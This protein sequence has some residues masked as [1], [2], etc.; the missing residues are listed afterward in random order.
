MLIKLFYMTPLISKK[1]LHQFVYD[2]EQFILSPNQLDKLYNVTQ[3]IL[4]Y[5]NNNL[6]FTE[7]FT[8]LDQQFKKIFKNHGILYAD[9]MH[10]GI[11]SVQFAKDSPDDITSNNL[12]SLKLIK[13]NFPPLLK[14]YIIRILETLIIDVADTL[15]DDNIADTKLL[16]FIKQIAV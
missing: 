3:V 12:I 5:F 6:D 1:H 8:E 14:L 15:H 2:K 11:I 10:W 4:N 16:S 13:S 7:D 9:Y